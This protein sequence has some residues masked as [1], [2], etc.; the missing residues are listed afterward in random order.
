MQPGLGVHF[1]A[2]LETNVTAITI[3]EAKSKQPQWHKG[4]AVEQS[5]STNLHFVFLSDMSPLSP[6][7]AL[8]TRGFII[9][10]SLIKTD[11]GALHRTL[12]SLT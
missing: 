6:Q 5:L 1:C 4:A 9:S 3:S 8:Q 11:D 7:V 10:R 12:W 2:F